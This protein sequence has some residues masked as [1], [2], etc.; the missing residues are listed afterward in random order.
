MDLVYK[1]CWVADAHQRTPRVYVI[2][3]T[4][5]LLIV[6]EREEEPFVLGLKHQTVR[7]EIC[8]LDV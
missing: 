7:L 8:P 2:L 5:E 6:L 4:V 3:P 1:V